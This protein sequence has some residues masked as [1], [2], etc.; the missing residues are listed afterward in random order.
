V[1]VI[2]PGAERA[3]EPSEWCGSL[4]VLERGELEFECCDGH[5]W[6]RARGEVMFLAGLPLRALR[7]EARVPALLSAVSRMLPAGDQFPPR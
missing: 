2:A 5:C 6:H 3:Y 7:N 4:V 1:F